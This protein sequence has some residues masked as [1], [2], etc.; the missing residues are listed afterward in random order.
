M[1][2]PRNEVGTMIKNMSLVLMKRWHAGDALGTARAIT[3]QRALL[4]EI[5]AMVKDDLWKAASISLGSIS[6]GD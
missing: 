1:D 6:G 5:E 2:I 3:R 4:D